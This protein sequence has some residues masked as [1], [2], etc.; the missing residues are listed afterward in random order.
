MVLITGGAGY[1]GSVTASLLVEQGYEVRILDNL[2]YDNYYV[3]EALREKGIKDF[4]KGDVRDRDVLSRAMKDVDAVLHMAALVGAPVCNRHP[5]LT[6]QVNY[7]ATKMVGDLCQELDVDRLVFA[8]STSVYGGIGGDIV[9]DEEGPCKPLSLYARTKLMSEEYLL[10]KSREEGLPVCCLRV[11]TNYG[12]S[13]RPRLDLA[14]NRFV[15]MALR[16]RKIEVYGGDQWRPF[17]NTYDTARAYQAVLEAP[18]GL[19]EGEIYNV[20][21]TS[22]NYR[23]IEVAEVVGEVIPGVEITVKEEHKDLR[24]YRVSFRKIEEKL[25]FRTV[26]ALREGIEELVD[27]VE[28]IED[29]EDEKYYNY[30]P[31]S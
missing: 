20:G 29:P 19:V 8:S 2:M 25:G 13:L 30:P 7:E 4:I 11:A 3:V 6:V 21:S 5:E 1:I 14:I 22:E 28:A 26:K 10:G 16:Y 15:Y 23:I 31:P 9:V 12:P 24:S 17:I 18:P 27:F